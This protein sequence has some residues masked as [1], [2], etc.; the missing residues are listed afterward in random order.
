MRRVVFLKCLLKCGKYRLVNLN[1]CRI[2]SFLNYIFLL[3]ETYCTV[4]IDYLYIPRRFIEQR[5]LR[6]L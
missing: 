4:T 2:F 6:K 1:I 3:G 5:I